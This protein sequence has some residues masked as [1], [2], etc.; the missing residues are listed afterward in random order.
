MLHGGP[1]ERTIPPRTT[2]PAAL[3]AGKYRVERLIAESVHSRIYEAVQTNLERRLALRRLRADAAE[4]HRSDV[5]AEARIC[6]RLGHPNVLAVYEMGADG[7]GPFV[8]MELLAGE[9]LREQLARGGRLDV[10][11]VARLGA[12]I[13]G[14]LV[15]AHEVGV[16]HP[17]LSPSKVF[18]SVVRGGHIA[19][20]SDFGEVGDADPRSDLHAAGVIIYEALTGAFPFET[21]TAIHEGRLPPGPSEVRDDVGLD[22]DAFTDRA[23]SSSL[24]ARFQSAEEMLDAWSS[25]EAVEP[26][27]RT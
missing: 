20:L 21:G 23:L 6:S 15:A 26:H 13:L 5:L 8:A 3:I 2:D 16:M 14:A 22:A 9:T 10:A 4:R 11:E 12:G 7:E 19:K 18:I 25:I 24:G 17:A 1:S 27:L